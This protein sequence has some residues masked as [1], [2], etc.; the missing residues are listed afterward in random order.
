MN[1]LIGVALA[2]ILFHSSLLHASSAPTGQYLTNV[3]LMQEAVRRG[4]EEMLR[5]LPAETEG[6]FAIASLGSSEIDWMVENE[7]AGVF[8]RSDR[9]LRILAGTGT[10]GRQRKR[11]TG[12]PFFFDTPPTFESGEP[13]RIPE[14]ACNEGIGGFV[15]VRILTN[16]NGSVANVVV[17]ESSAPVLE[18]AVLSTVNSYQFQPAMKDDSAIAGH[19]VFGFT[20]PE[21]PEDCEDVLVTGELLDSDEFTSESPP[22]PA[23]NA[24][25][26]I[27]DTPTLAYRVSEMEFVYPR[28]HRRFGIGRQSVDRF[29]RARIDFR[30]Q[31]QDAVLWASSVEYYVSDRVPKSA[32]TYLASTQYEFAA[33]ELPAT[34]SFAYWEPVV[35]AGVV[36]GLVALFYSNQANQ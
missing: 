5:D 35:V 27:G 29:A 23:G 2:A 3:E 12:L 16:G 30:L 17:E 20:F 24:L 9:P 11:T 4:L 32:L 13:V 28:S 6:A 1:R 26:A 36:G 25:A 33:P 34:H 31:E 8:A 21:A 15:A 18:E 19:T 7:L 14:E 10:P 22:E